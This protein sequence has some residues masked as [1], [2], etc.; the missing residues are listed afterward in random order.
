[1][2]DD[3]FLTCHFVDDMVMPG[4]LMYECCAHTLRVLLLRMGWVTDKTEVC[5]EPVQ[6]VDCGLKCRGPVTPQT[7][8]VHYTVEIKEIGYHPEPYVIADAHMY[9]DDHYIVFFKDMSMQMTGVDGEDIA[10]FWD[11]RRNIMTSKKDSPQEPLFTSEHILEFA[12]GC[13]SKA[14]GQPYEV[15]D[16]QRRIARLPGPPYCFIDRITAIQP[17]PWLLEPDGWVLAQ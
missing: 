1:H 6:A 15:F 9:A 7:R 11:A 3:W 10:S 17:K 5:Y 12:V 16:R 14:F 13:P 8:H 4:T 2:P